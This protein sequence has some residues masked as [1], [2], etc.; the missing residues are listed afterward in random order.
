MKDRMVDH[1]GHNQL[2]Q[3]TQ[4]GFMSKKSCLTNLLDF[5]EKI[6]NETDDGKPIDII[7]LDFAKAFDKVPKIRLLSKIKSHSISGR[8]LGWIESCLSGRKQR[9][10]LNGNASS[11][12][13]VLSGVPQGSVLGPLVFIIFINNIDQVA[14]LIALI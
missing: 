9:V 11:W 3:N 8:F 4:H 6:T 10:V 12:A 13:D 7:Y 5:L 1:L 14:A 2:I